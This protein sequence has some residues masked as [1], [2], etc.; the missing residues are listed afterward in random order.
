VA[1]PN[2]LLKMTVQTESDG[3]IHTILA[4]L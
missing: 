1:A 4:E 3:K 2:N